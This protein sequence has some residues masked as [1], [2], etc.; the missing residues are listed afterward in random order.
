MSK[1]IANIIYKF[2][3]LVLLILIISGCGISKYRN[4]SCDDLSSKDATVQAI[5]IKWAG[6]NKV[7]DALGPLINILEYEDA[8]LRFYAQQAIEKITDQD[9]GYCYS[10]PPEKRIEAVQRWRQYLKQKNG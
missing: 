4:I 1:L 9:M 5:A 3:A 7:N 8:A 2:T 10:D 6:D